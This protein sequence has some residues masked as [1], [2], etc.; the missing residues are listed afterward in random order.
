MNRYQQQYQQQ[1]LLEPRTPSIILRTP[2]IFSSV[3]LMGFRA[4]E[5]SIAQRR[6]QAREIS[7]VSHQKIIVIVWLT[8]QHS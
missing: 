7:N 5:L 6:W 2:T 3:L 8:Y 1:Q 4:D